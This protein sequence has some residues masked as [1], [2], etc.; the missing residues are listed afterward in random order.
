MPNNYIEALS[1][2]LRSEIRCIKCDQGA[3]N[4][5]I[6]YNESKEEYYSK[7]GDYCSAGCAMTHVP[8]QNL[9]SPRTIIDPE[10]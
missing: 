2:F 10:N 1:Q 9:P 8:H 5:S 4:F 3:N 7:W 6:N